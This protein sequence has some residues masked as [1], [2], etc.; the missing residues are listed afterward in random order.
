V[1]ANE[2]DK[3]SAELAKEAE[4][5]QTAKRPGY[6]GGNEDVLRNFKVVADR[7]DTV[8][9]HCQQAHKLTAHNVWAVYFLKH[10]DAILSIMNRPDL[11]VSEAAIG[12]F[13]DARNY[14]ALGYALQQERDNAHVI[15]KQ[16]RDEEKLKQFDAAVVDSIAQWQSYRAAKKFQPVTPHPLQLRDSGPKAAT[17]LQP[18]LSDGRPA[19]PPPATLCDQAQIAALGAHM[20]RVRDNGVMLDPGGSV[21]PV[22]LDLYHPGN[23]VI[24][25]YQKIAGFEASAGCSTPY[26]GP[27]TDS[28][29]RLASLP[30]D[31]SP[32]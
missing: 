32:L 19:T 13:S 7:I 22:P 23:N 1:N 10:I 5:I 29:V 15:E 2:Y 17:T 8:C 16:R 11:P 28:T 6:T 30:P 21:P 18:V 20:Q 9:P 4:G 3:L 26:S 27:V 14:G 24:H 25:D 31:T 12:R